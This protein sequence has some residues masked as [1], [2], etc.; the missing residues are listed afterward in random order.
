METALGANP[1]G[2][3]SVNANG[4]LAYA[5]TDWSGGAGNG[6][7]VLDAAT[8]AIVWVLDDRAEYPE[9]AQPVWSDGRLF[10]ANTDALVMWGP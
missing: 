9:F 10:A 3:G 2:S 6:V 4:L 7:S 1:L 5:G 8:G